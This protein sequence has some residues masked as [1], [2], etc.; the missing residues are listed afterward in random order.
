MNMFDNKNLVFLERGYECPN[1]TDS[2]EAGKTFLDLYLGL[3]DDRM[4]SMEIIYQYHLMANEDLG[5]LLFNP[6]N[7]LI[8][9]SMYVSGSDYDFLGYAEE[10]GK[11]GVKFINY[12]CTSGKLVEFLKRKLAYGELKSNVIKGINNNTI[13]VRNDDVEKGYSIL[14]IKKKTIVLE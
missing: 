9:F 4:D 1:T 2:I 6:N 10:I 12:I 5:K 3:S 14:K 13:I 7:T 11:S 8:T